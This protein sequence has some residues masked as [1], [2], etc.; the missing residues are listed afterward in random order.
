MTEPPEEDLDETGADTG[1]EV[2]KWKA[3]ARKHEEQ[4]KANSAAA[5]RLAALEEAQKTAEQKAAEARTAAEKERDDA[6]LELLKRDAADEA[7]L[8]KSWASRLRGTTKE[9]LEAD[10][11]ELA[12]DLAPKQQASQ[13]RAV[14]DLKS[15]ALP[16]GSSAPFD[17]DT[18]I[19]KQAGVQ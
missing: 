18:W 11:K 6:R 17:A 5:K 2:E 8:P 7:G 10:A 14:P 3:L 13:S 4:A 19:R 1:Q 16:G 9:E 12:K 15:G